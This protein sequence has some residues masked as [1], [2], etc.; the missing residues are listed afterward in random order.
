MN[1]TAVSAP[2][3]SLIYSSCA[4]M[5]PSFGHIIARSVP[6]RKNG[7]T[8]TRHWGISCNEHL[9]PY[10]LKRHNIA[11]KPHRY[12]Q[13]IYALF[14]GL[15]IFR[16]LLSVEKREESGVDRRIFFSVYPFLYM[17]LNKYLI[18]SHYY[19]YY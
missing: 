16:Y 3:T 18:H 17:F 4:I 6:Y 15:D 13:C 5:L 11:V 7:L 9:R 2:G 10:A 8:Y 1:K 14:Q 19:Q 12:I